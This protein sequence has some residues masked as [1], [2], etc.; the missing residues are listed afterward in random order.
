[1]SRTPSRTRWS[2]RYFPT[3]SHRNLGLVTTLLTSIATS[4]A[5]TATATQ[6]PGCRTGTALISSGGSL[7]PA[8]RRGSAGWSCRP[9]SRAPLIT[10]SVIAPSE[11]SHRSRIALYVPSA[12][13]AFTAPSTASFSRPGRSSPDRDPV[14]RG[15]VVLPDPLEPAADLLDRRDHDRQVGEHR[16]APGRARRRWWP[17]P[18]FRTAGSWIALA[19]RGA[20]LAPRRQVVCVLHGAGLHGDLLAAGVVRIEVD[21]PSPPT[22]VPALKYVTKSTDLLA[23]LGVGERRHAQLVPAAERGM[24][25]VELRLLELGGQPELLGDRGA[26]VDVEADDLAAGV[27]ELVGLVGRVGA[28]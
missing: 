4:T 11:T 12:M 3:V 16:V 18:G 27:L 14:R 8:A 17:R 22:A 9:S 2:N 28:R 13:S 20:R 10:G 24:I 5:S 7:P 15:V 1:M 19:G 21:V 23:L 26:E 6:R 25:V